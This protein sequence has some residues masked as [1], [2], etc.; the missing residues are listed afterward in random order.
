MLKLGDTHLEVF[1]FASPAPA[2]RHKLRPVC[3][4]GIT[5]VCLL[6]E[7]LQAEYERMRT[8]GMTF[9]SPPLRQDSGYVIYGRDVDGN[10]IE[11]IEFT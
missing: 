8:A 11:L 9:H 10:V 3:D 2:A 6:V 5:H 7:D 4:H 1:E